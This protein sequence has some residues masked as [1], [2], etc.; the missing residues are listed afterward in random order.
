MPPSSGSPRARTIA[1]FA[2]GARQAVVDMDTVG[3]DTETAQ[4]VAL[5][6]EVLLI[7]GASGVPDE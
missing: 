2:V 5:S 1:A 7:G 4:P 3:L 6:S